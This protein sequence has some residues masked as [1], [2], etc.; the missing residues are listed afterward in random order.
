MRTVP[1]ST[2]ASTTASAAT[3]SPSSKRHTVQLNTATDRVI[4]MRAM[5]LTHPGQRLEDTI[6]RDPRAGP[7]QVVV[8]VEACGVC[9]TD[10]HIADG[11]LP[12]A[13]SRSSPATRSSERWPRSVLA[14]MHLRAAIAWECPGLRGLWQVRILP[15]GQG[16][17]LRSRSVYRIHDRRR[18]CG[19]PG[20]RRSILLQD[21]ERRASV[22]IGTMALRRF[23]RYRRCARQGMRGGSEFTD[24][25]RPPTSWL[26]SRASGVRRCMRSPGRVT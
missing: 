3:A 1:A 2:A 11:E 14:L 7:G 22:L 20:R 21:A 26:R 4:R 6:V 13:R 24:S 17:P 18:I 9:R 5:V 25:E 16:E 8:Q 12:S 15:R 19:V 23:D 10:L